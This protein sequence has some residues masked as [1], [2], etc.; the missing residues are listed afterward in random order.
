MRANWIVI[1]GHF[2]F[3]LQRNVQLGINVR[4]KQIYFSM[5]SRHY[6]RSIKEPVHQ[7]QPSS[8]FRTASASLNLPSPYKYVPILILIP[9]LRQLGEKDNFIK[10]RQVKS[11]NH[12]RKNEQNKVEYVG[13]ENIQGG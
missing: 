4:P 8:G 7:S 5:I 3:C 10:T 11:L 13:R 9:T 6:W 2:C 1:Y 12:E